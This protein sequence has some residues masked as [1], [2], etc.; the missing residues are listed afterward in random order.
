MRGK[1]INSLNALFLVLLLFALLF[2][3]LFAGEDE[4]LEDTFEYAPQTIETL[5]NLNE[6]LYG[7]SSPAFPE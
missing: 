6:T 7:T 4:P 5:E 3:Y 1:K 2:A